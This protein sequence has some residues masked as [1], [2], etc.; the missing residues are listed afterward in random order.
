MKQDFDA[1]RVV[2]LHSGGVDPS[3]LPQECGLPLPVSVQ[4]FTD[5]YPS[6]QNQLNQGL[7]QAAFG[8]DHLLI[9]DLVFLDMTPDFKEAMYSQGIS[10]KPHT[11]RIFKS[12]EGV[13]HI[14]TAA[15]YDKTAL[16]LEITNGQRR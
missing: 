4:S 15:G 10:S 7:R 3:I 12:G 6:A 13:V 9:Q 11:A 5:T 1:T 14:L 8:A 2:I 16:E